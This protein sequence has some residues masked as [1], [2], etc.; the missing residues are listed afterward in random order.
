MFNIEYDVLEE[1]NIGETRFRLVEDHSRKT[2]KIQLWSS[3][4]KQWNVTH[5]RNVDSEWE[6]W[7]LTA[8]RIQNRKA[9]Q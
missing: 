7:K 5:R 8:A 1:L 6:K 2:R 9:Q 3:L 4:S